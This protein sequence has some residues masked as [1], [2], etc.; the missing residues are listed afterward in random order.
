MKVGPC[1]R[2]EPVNQKLAQ[3]EARWCGHWLLKGCCPILMKVGPCAHESSVESQR[4][5]RRDGLGVGH[6]VVL[7]LE[8]HQET[9]GLLKKKKKQKGTSH[10]N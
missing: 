9:A 10:A 5:K 7:Q 1:V 8:M 2:E 6:E 4:K 3:E